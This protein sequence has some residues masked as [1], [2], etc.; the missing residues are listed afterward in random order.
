MRVLVDYANRSWRV[1]SCYRYLSPESPQMRGSGN[2]GNLFHVYRHGE[3]NYLA[4]E[5]I[6]SIWKI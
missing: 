1:H 5:S 4:V 6:P 2:E 3:T